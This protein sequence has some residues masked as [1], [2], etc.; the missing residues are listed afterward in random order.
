VE[1]F[2]TVDLSIGGFM[3]FIE[4]FLFVSACVSSMLHT[5]LAYIFYYFS[6]F[7]A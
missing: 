3:V 4:Q 5:G 7:S 6:P 2:L 1:K